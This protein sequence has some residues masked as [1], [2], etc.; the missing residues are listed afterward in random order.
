MAAR[1]NPPSFFDFCSNYAMNCE[2][3]EDY[4]LALFHATWLHASVGQFSQ[5]YRFVCYFLLQIFS[6]GDENS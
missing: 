3:Y 6:I 1:K 5:L 2:S 4:I